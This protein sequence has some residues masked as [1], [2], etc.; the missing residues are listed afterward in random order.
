MGPPLPLNSNVAR[1]PTCL[2]YLLNICYFVAPLQQQYCLNYLFNC[3]YTAL[4][5]DESSYTL[6]PK[7]FRVPLPEALFVPQSLGE[8][9]GGFLELPVLRHLHVPFSKL[10]T[11]KGSQTVGSKTIFNV[12][13]RYIFETFRVRLKLW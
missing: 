6:T 7:G 4:D 8:N 1:L 11:G 5:H 3:V 13:G 2:F 9:R 10:N 12:F